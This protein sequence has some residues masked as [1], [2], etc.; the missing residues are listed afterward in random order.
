MGGGAQSGDML[1][2]GFVGFDH[3][4]A[5]EDMKQYF[6][7]KIRQ[8]GEPRLWMLQ[9]GLVSDFVACF[10]LDLALRVLQVIASHCRPAALL[11]RTLTSK[12]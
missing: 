3:V 5:I 12:E 2:R 8:I 11:V 10:F 6:D 4:A 9:T 7:A 1:P